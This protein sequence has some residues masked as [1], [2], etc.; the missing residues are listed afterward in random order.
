[1]ISEEAKDKIVFGTT[2]KELL[3]HGCS[4]EFQGSLKS[5]SSAYLTGY[6][7]GKKIQKQKLETP[8]VDL[9]M[10]RTSPKTKVFSFIKG[11]IDSGL[12]ISC[13]EDVFPEEDR[14]I[15]KHLKKDFSSEFNK[16]K[17]NLDKI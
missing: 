11:L 10:I 13:K 2:S 12:E 17:S 6:L 1:V 15:G 9:G 16:I 5:V 14:I 7:V 8:I 4:K 3:L